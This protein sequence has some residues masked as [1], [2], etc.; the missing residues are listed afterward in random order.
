[1]SIL[2][3]INL[4]HTNGTTAAIIATDGRLTSLVSPTSGQDAATKTYVDSVTPILSN[5]LSGLTLSTAGASSS[6]SVSSGMAANSSNSTYISLA[7]SISKTTSSWTVGTGLGGLDTGS[8]AASTWYYFFVIRR[9]DTAVV[10]VIFSLNSTTP[11]LPANYTQYRY[12]GGGRTNGSSQWTKFLQV[13]DD[14]W[15][16]AAVVDFTGSSTTTASTLNCTIP[17]GRKMKGLF[18]VGY[19][20]TNSTDGVL[21]S[22]PDRTDSA[23][24]RTASPLTSWS[25][26]TDTGNTNGAGQVVCYTNTSGQIRHRALTVRSGLV[27]GT[28]GWTDLR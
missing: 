19:N 6:M 16:D 10:D 18:V 3:T 26:G 1:M 24:S 9:P 25:I 21:L 23:P 14:F 27:I 2:K 5:Y 8:I 7:S 4:Q 17:S 28:L 22:D 15:W 11:T 12:I 13:G 20:G